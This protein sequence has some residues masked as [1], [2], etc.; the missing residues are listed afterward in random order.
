MPMRTA[1]ALLLL[2]AVLACAPSEGGRTAAGDP[3]GEPEYRGRVLPRPLEKPDF[4]LADTRGR[5]F[6]FREETQ[7][8][9]ALL[10]IGY[11]NCP[12]VCP[13]HMA[14][15]AAV[16]GDLPLRVGQDVEVVFVTADP[17]RDTPE[18]IRSWLDRFHR[19]FVGLRGTREEVNA[20]EEA[21]KLPPSV[22]DVDQETGEP[23]VGHASHVVAFTADG[24][25]HVLYPFGTR[26]SDWA[27]DL[28]KL[29]G[30]EWS[31]G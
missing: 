8:T 5:P 20:I 13:V 2:P 26:Q 15:L 4:T 18:V 1:A 16:L 23:F 21:L 6:D 28:P 7:G 11:T 31:G 14:N 25:A 29:A 10:F 22:V 3:G 9:L 17:E 30:G 19:G 27:H 12:D 24:K